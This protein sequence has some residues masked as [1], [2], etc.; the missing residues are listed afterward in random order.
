MTVVTVTQQPGGPLRQA[1]RVRGRRARLKKRWHTDRHGAYQEFADI[2][3]EQPEWIASMLIA[4]L[5]D[6]LPQMGPVRRDV[7]IRRL[8]VRGHVPVNELTVREAK[9]LTDWARAGGG[10][11]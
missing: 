10:V 1:N 5:I 8:M 9:S 2:V 3:W 4:D 6:A 7:T 11:P